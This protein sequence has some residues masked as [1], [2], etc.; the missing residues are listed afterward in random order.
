LGHFLYPKRSFYQDRLGTDI[1]KNSKQDRSCRQRFWNESAIDLSAGYVPNS[2]GGAKHPDLSAAA[3]LSV[4]EGWYYCAQY[5]LASTTRD[6][7]VSP[8]LEG[9]AVVEPVAWGDQF[10]LDY[11]AEANTWG[12]GDCS[13]TNSAPFTTLSCWFCLDK[14]RVAD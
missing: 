12:A 3:N 4:V 13:R 6:G 8:S 14:L 11:N 9:L 1:R 2:T 5:L 10:T 7:K